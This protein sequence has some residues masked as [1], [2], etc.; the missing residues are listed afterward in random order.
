MELK[1]LDEFK[2]RLRKAR[3]TKSLKQFKSLLWGCPFPPL[4]EYNPE[5]GEHCPTCPLSDKHGPKKLLGSF[6][7][8]ILGHMKDI[9]MGS[10]SKQIDDEEALAILILSA[11]RVLEYLEGSW[12]REWDSEIKTRDQVRE[13][14]FKKS[15]MN[16]NS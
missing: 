1:S 16:T 10:L 14:F 8:C 5:S 12:K 13:E 11:T 9:C 4:Y 3:D 7:T 15:L 6:K 2:N